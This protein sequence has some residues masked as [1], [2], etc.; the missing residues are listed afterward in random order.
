MVPQW[1]PD[2]LLFLCIFSLSAGP[3]WWPL[4]NNT[5]SGFSLS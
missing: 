1:Q 2:S 3:L 4:F 5:G